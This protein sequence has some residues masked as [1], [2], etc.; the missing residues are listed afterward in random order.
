MNKERPTPTDKLTKSGKIIL[1]D[2]SIDYSFKGPIRL[3]RSKKWLD[4]ETYEDARKQE[5]LPKT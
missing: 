4:A 3:N 5:K 1:S 2:G